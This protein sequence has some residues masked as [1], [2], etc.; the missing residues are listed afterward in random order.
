MVGA[1][2]VELDVV[3]AGVEG[4]ALAV[5]IEVPAPAAG[6][7]MRAIVPNVGDAPARMENSTSQQLEQPHLLQDELFK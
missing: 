3:L 2:L 4:L 1:H 7:V 6:I 5:D